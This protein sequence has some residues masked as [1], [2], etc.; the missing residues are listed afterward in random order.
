MT[1]AKVVRKGSYQ[2]V[3]QWGISTSSEI[4]P[5]RA[6]A[7]KWADLENA[8]RKQ[9]D[10][11]NCGKTL[12]PHEY[13]IGRHSWDCSRKH[14]IAGSGEHGCLYD[15]CH[16][17]R[18]YKDAVDGL[19]ETFGLGRSRR[20]RLGSDGYLELNP[21]RD[22]AEYCEITACTCATPWIHDENQSEEDWTE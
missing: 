4:T 21:G 20:L 10:C 18:T 16:V 12:Q 7:Q 15:S 6:I 13:S 3:P 2:G 5:N 17:Y 1:L 14:F 19:A 22:G 8:A 11:S 9:H